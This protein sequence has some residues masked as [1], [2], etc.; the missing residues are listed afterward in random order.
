[1]TDE[2][3]LVVGGGLAGLTAALFT[4]RAG[5]DTRVV[6]TGEPI[7]RRNAHLE[8]FPG[9]PAGVNPRL[10]L[11]STREQA[12]RNG[13]RF[14]DARVE[15]VSPLDP[16]DPSYPEDGDLG[17]AD[18]TAGFTVSVPDGD[19]LTATY[20]VAASWSDPS[21]LDDLDVSLVQRGSKQFVGVDDLGRTE[22]D[23]LYAAGRLAKQYH[24]AVVAAG[25]GAQVAITLVEDSD[26][27][28]YHDWVVPEGYFTGR[29]REVPPGCEEIDEAERRRRE[30][31]ARAAIRESVADPH[32]DE[33][34]M[35][36][37]VADEE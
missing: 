24:Q 22:V 25:H 9:F 8:N 15:R 37:S 30:D 27:P 31:E 12:E 2:D 5:L 21:Y 14:T 35:H 3:V 32:P 17:P 16:D 34:T 6:S 36:P 11:D 23:G 18:E 1:M 33:P 28:F 4:A 29:D 26:R 20:V 10:L 7:L 19:A 13:V